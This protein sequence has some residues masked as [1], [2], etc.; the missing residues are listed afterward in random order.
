[1]NQWMECSGGGCLDNIIYPGDGSSVRLPLLPKPQQ[2][3]TLLLLLVVYIRKLS[4]LYCKSFSQSLSIS[5][6]FFLSLFAGI[7]SSI[8]LSSKYPSV[9]LLLPLSFSISLFFLCYFSLV[10]FLSLSC[11]Y[12]LPLTPLLYLIP[13]LSLSLSLSPSLSPSSSATFIWVF[14][15]LI[16]ILT[17]SGFAWRHAIC[18]RT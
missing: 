17:L 5:F 9:C 4:Q 1:M 6:C 8:S 10:R 14:F 15:S 18:R 2:R 16:V 13:S 11:L 3:L 12:F 7:S